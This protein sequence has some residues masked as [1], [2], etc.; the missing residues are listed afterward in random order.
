MKT[1]AKALRGKN[2]KKAKEKFERIAKR[3]NTKDEYWK[4]YHRA[5][6]GMVA[7]LESGDD[8]TFLKRVASGKYSSEDIKRY[9]DEMRVK[10]NQDFRPNDER[11]YHA[12]WVEVLDVFLEMA[13]KSK[14]K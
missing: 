6:E 8:L 10:V 1:F 4:G 13:E 9:I 2:A 3:L 7:A 14:R 5:L 11:G 12:A